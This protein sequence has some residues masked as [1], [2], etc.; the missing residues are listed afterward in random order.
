MAKSSALVAR[1]GAGAAR[2]KRGRLFSLCPSR[3]GAALRG[4]RP[5][6]DRRASAMHP[7]PRMAPKRPCAAQSQSTHRLSSRLKTVPRGLA[8][9]CVGFAETE[10]R[11]IAPVPAPAFAFFL[12]VVGQAGS[13]Q[14]VLRLSTDRASVGAWVTLAPRRGRPHPCGVVGRVIH[15][16]VHI[17]PFDTGKPL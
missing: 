13:G 14:P 12:N 15:A 1:Q 11:P 6:V 7:G 8:R 16:G 4:S 2:P 9:P 5:M 17:E 3:R 10:A